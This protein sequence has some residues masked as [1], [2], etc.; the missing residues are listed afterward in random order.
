MSIKSTKFS[1]TTLLKFLAYPNNKP[2]CAKC[3]KNAH[4]T[5]LD[6]HHKDG[7]PMNRD[8]KNIVI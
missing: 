5:P 4:Q 6:L 7:N 1:Q 8:W 2:V 3:G